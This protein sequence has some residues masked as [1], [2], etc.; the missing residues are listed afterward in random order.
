MAMV[1]GPNACHTAMLRLRST[2][3]ECGEPMILDIVCLKV[4]YRVRTPS[5]A[6]QI[7]LLSPGPNLPQLK[8]QLRG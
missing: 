7:K 2:E 6:V 8:S 5:D 1:Q 3:N 4:R